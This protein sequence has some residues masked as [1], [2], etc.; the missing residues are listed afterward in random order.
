ML[1]ALRAVVVVMV[2]RLRVSLCSCL[3][4]GRGRIGGGFSLFGFLSLRTVGALMLSSR[5]FEA[6]L[7]LQ[8]S[9]AIRG[10]RHVGTD[11]ERLRLKEELHDTVSQRMF[12]LSMLTAR[13]QA[14]ARTAGQA[15]LHAR[16]T[17]LRTLVADASADIRLLMGEAPSPA[18]GDWLSARLSSM[19]RCRCGF[20]LRSTGCC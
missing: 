17:E 7:A 13:A 5:A 19:V 10:A 3:P 16:L 20:R 15:D 8:Y 18:D 11:H 6:A 1:W 9:D 4:L 12:G 2:W 14:D